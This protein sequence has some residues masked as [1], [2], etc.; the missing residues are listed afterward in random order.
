MVLEIEELQLLI[1]DKEEMISELGDIK[2]RYDESRNELEDMK[3]KSE[4]SDK[5]LQEMI[6]KF[7]EA[8]NGLNSSKSEVETIKHQLEEV[9]VINLR[10]IK[11]S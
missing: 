1:K 9:K 7:E 2:I 5:E 4:M 6:K 8:T 3:K 10:I 11:E